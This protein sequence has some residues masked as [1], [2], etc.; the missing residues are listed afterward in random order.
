M[1]SITTCNFLVGELEKLFPLFQP[2]TPLL[3]GT[4]ETQK[5]ASSAFSQGRSAVVERSQ[6]LPVLTLGVNP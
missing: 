4:P 5:R 3:V 6:K 2:L 1:W